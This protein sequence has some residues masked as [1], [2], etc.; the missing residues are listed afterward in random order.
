M[1]R[2]LL[3]NAL[4]L[5]LCAA[6]IVAMPARAAGPAYSWNNVKIGGSGYVPGII[7]H[8]GQQGL[9]YARTDVGGAYRYNASTKTWTPL[10][11]WISSAQFN[12]SG[13]DS[14]AVDPRD[15]NKLYLVGGIYYSGGN[16]TLMISNNQGNTFTLVPLGFTAGGNER[17]RQVG[18]RLM[19]DP[20]QGSVLF[21]GTGNYAGS[22]SSNGL[23]KSSNGGAN[24]SRVSGFPAL[25][26]DGTGA[27]I[28]FVAF[29]KGSGSAGQATP[30]L[31]AGINT[32]TA[33]QT[34]SKLYKSTD[35]GNNWSPVWGGPGGLQPQRGQIGPDG[36]LY[37]TFAAWTSSTDGNGKV[38][39]HYG[40]DGLTKGQVWKYDIANNQWAYITPWSSNNTNGEY[41]WGFSGLSV[42]PSHP[43]RLMVNTIDRY[44]SQ[45]ETAYVSNDGGAHWTDLVANATFDSSAAPWNTVYGPIHNLG[46]WSAS[47]L[48]PFNTSHAFV[49]SGGGIMESNNLTAANPAWAYGEN[50]IEETVLNALISPPPNQY[51]ATPLISGGG[52]V[53]GFVHNSVTT[54][55]SQPFSNPTCNNVTGMDYAKTNSTFVVRVGNDAYGAV[56]HYGAISWNGGYSW[57]AFNSNGTAVDGGGYVAVNADGSS[58]LWAPKDAPPAYSNNNAYSWNSLSGVLPNNVRIVADGYNAN[59]FYAYDRNVGTFYASSDKGATWAA[60]NAGLIAWGDQLAAP[61]GQGGDVWLVT[62]TGLYHTTTSGWGAWVKAPGVTQAGALGFGKAAAGA[63]YPAMYMEGTA[64][65]VWGIHRSTDGG[66]TW[67]RINDDQHQWYGTNHVIT[68]DPKTFGTVYI[69]TNGRGILYGTSAN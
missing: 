2:P 22:A 36:N 18:E 35:G 56:K 8:P 34:G 19:V 40:P 3:L 32:K 53:C 54:A 66:N 63:S 42:D 46:N 15:P 30:V 47:V 20:N 43:G 31:F 21:Y 50:G 68:G 39:E 23:W 67:V 29:H 57:S 44:D 61:A 13:I 7:A 60:T 38:W 58:I 28:S 51:G 16:A 45:G 41:S 52:D 4:L 1:K 65:G 55:P 69:G 49:T 27:G 62:Y 33:E 26:S 11:D 6:N 14:I 59:L 64:N 25:S 10:N 5:S 24:W 9:F 48:D 12:M 17:G 37:I